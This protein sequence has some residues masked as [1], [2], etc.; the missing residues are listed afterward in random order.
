MNRRFAPKIFTPEKFTTL[1]A[2]LALFVCAVP[3]ADAMVASLDGAAFHNESANDAVAEIWNRTVQ[4]SAGTGTYLG[5]SADGTY[6][7]LTAAH[8]SSGGGTIATSDGQT[9]ALT[10]ANRSETLKNEDGKNADIKLVA[11][12]ATGTAADY[13]EALGDLNIYT[14]TLTT[15][16]PLVCVGTGCSLSIGSSYR[17]GS[18]VKQWAAFSADSATKITEAAY[19]TDCYGEIFSEKGYSF[20]GGLYDSGSGVFVNENGAWA[21]VGAAIT[22]GGIGADATLVGYAEN[23]SNENPLIYDT[24]FSNL[25]GYADQIAA[26]MA[27][28]EPSSFGLFAGALAAALAAATTRRRSRRK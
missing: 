22:V 8:V 23:A 13:L 15:V 18:R 17:T 10:Y 20:Q 24:Y 9:I 26:I 14:G 27:I 16:T 2:A 7:V 12:S 11:V 3:A 4:M 1:A 25:S 21:L 28:P 19:A 5:K 6:W